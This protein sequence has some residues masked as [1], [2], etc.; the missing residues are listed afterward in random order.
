M[1]KATIFDA[2]FEELMDVTQDPVVVADGFAF[3]E[4]PIW[5]GKERHLT[6]SDFPNNHLYRWSREGGLKLIREHTNKANGNAYDHLGRII[7]CEGTSSRVARMEADMSGYEVLATHYGG[8]QLNS[9]NDVVVHSNGMIY[10]T[11]P[12]FGRRP[13]GAGLGRPQ[14]LDFQGVY[15]LNPDTLLLTLVADQVANPNGLCFSLDERQMYIADSPR[16]CIFLFD[17]LSDG[18]LG[19]MRT[20][21]VTA[22]KGEGKPDGVK[23]DME[24]NVWCT[25]QGGVQV[26]NK[27]GRLLAAIAFPERSGN[28]CFGGDDLKTLFVCAGSTVQTLRTKV[29][30]KKLKM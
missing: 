9:P 12:Q 17:V 3:T 23:I 5:H 30:G 21:G 26:F 6:F 18:T 28:L 29:P 7:S 14:E 10:F 24:G 13:T 25:A 22:D 15:M 16:H 1:L 27:G 20:F 4:G 11:D 2:G 8:K 19:N